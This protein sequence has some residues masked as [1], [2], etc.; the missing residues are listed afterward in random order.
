MLNFFEGEVFKVLWR[1]KYYNVFEMHEYLHYYLNYNFL[2]PS[3]EK[4]HLVR[5]LLGIVKEAG[6]T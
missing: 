4:T 5:I 3:A 6:S 2:A 1:N